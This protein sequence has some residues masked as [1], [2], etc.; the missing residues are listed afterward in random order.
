[1]KKFTILISVLFV[2]LLNGCS[3]HEAFV[4]KYNK[5]VG[6]NI[7]TL[8]SVEGYPNSSYDVPNG[9]KVYVYSRSTTSYVPGFGGY[10]GRRAYFGWSVAYDEVITRNCT[11]FF[12][13]DKKGV[14][15]K[16]GA[17]GDNCVA[18]EEK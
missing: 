9:N 15:I 7:S 4:K 13:V 12:E 1:M 17:R 18:A 10:F 5:W 6:Q 16:W 14:I 3:T 11:T 2:F 8:I